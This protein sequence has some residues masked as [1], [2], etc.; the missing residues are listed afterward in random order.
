MR[1]LEST[2]WGGWENVPPES[3]RRIEDAERSAELTSEKLA[4]VMYE[5]DRDEAISVSNFIQNLDIEREML[6]S[7]ERI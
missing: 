5:A 1:L 2:I 4:E 3:K 6:G 7:E